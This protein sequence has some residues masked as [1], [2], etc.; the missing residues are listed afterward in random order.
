MPRKAEKTYW[1]GQVKIYKRT[2]FWWAA[3]TADRN[4]KGSEY[5]RHSLRVTTLEAAKA[6]AAEIT[7]LL[8]TGQAVVLNSRESANMTLADWIDEWEEEYCTWS[9]SYYERAAYTLTYWRKELG[10][11]ALGG[12]ASGD[13]SRILER[14]L[15]R[16]EISDA[17]FNRYLSVI[18]KVYS[19]A[20]E[21]NI[22]SHNPAMDVRVRREDKKEPHPYSPEELARLLPALP[23]DLREIAHVYLDTGMRKGS[24]VKLQWNHVDFIGGML[25]VASKKIHYV[26]PMTDRVRGILSDLKRTQVK[27]AKR[28]GIVPIMVYGRTADI[29][30]PL[31]KAAAS[32]DVENATVHRFRDTFAT[33]LLSR[34]APVEKVQKLMGHLH[35]AMTLRYAQILPEQLEDAIALRGR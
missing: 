32:V 33:E 28:T 3:Y 2:R 26:V 18:R 19:S 15:S 22:L 21:K 20:M 23:E 4:T 5:E 25:H 24:L 30:K 12:V 13:I 6:K 14:R 27:E 9:D 34:G 1:I 35:I 17:S 16:G 10:D 7:R 11:R 29:L 31:W 8:E